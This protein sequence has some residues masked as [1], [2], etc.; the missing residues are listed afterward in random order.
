MCVEQTYPLEPLDH[1]RAEF[2]LGVMRIAVERFGYSASDAM[3]KTILERNRNG[4]YAVEWVRG[5]WEGF[6]IA[7]PLAIEQEAQR[8]DATRWQYYAS[9]VAAKLGITLE[10]MTR[11]I[12]W[13]IESE[14]AGGA[15]SESKLEL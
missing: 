2:E 6:N 11:E 15:A 5:A 12:D 4:R 3:L 1:K 13:A 8:R 7:Q 14:R 9:K 10:E